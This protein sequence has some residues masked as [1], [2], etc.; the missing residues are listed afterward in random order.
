MSLL[1]IRKKFDIICKG[2]AKYTL[3]IYCAHRLVGLLLAPIIRKLEL[4]DTIWTVMVIY[5]GSVFL[6]LLIEHLFW[7]CPIFRT[8][9]FFLKTS[10]DLVS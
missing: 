10:K 8:Q 7:L 5:V 6:C 2:L 4:D 9:P 3:G 1:R